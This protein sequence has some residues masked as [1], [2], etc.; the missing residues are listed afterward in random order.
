MSKPLIVSYTSDHGTY[1]T[2]YHV[3]DEINYNINSSKFNSKC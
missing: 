2:S 3:I 1:D